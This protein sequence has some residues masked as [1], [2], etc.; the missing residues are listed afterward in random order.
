MRARRRITVA[1]PSVVAPDAPTLTA[2]ADNA[3]VYDGV[4]VTVSATVTA[5]QVPDRIDF[6]LDPGP[7]EVVVA[8]DS[9]SPYSQAWTPSGVTPGA[10]TL[11][12]RFVY[13]SG[14]VDSAAADIVLF[15]PTVLTGLEAW[16]RADLGI[17][18]DGSD[19]VSQWDDQSG[20]GNHLSQAVGSAQPTWTAGAIGG[21]AAVVG[22]GAD[23]MQA[24]FAGA[25]AQPTSVLVV[26]RPD[27]LAALS[28]FFASSS[29][30]NRQ[31]AVYTP[32]TALGIFAGG[33]LVYSGTVALSTPC[34]FGAEYNGASSVIRK[35]GV[36]GAPLNPGAAS[37]DGVTLFA[38][39]DGTNLATAAIAEAVVFAGV[40][41]AGDWQRLEGYAEALY[42]IAVP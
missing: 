28:F 34:I 16:Y 11:V 26:L 39:G 19:K 13:G 40:L 31:D 2:P 37:T 29:M 17:T 3:D 35:D 14:S 36:P 7:G 15:D 22:D 20:N 33:S 21:R 18:K 41:S 10:H 30:V 5:G 42:G 25:L 12:A 23:Y 4:A 1:A 32:G 8:T 38:R 9:S 27:S 24:S 6:V